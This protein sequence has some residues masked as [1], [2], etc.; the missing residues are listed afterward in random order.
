MTHPER[1]RRFFA[2]SVLV[3]VVLTFCVAPALHEFSHIGF[4]SEGAHLDAT[5]V[6]CSSTS[7]TPLAND[8]T[9]V[10]CPDPSWSPVAVAFESTPR[11]APNHS[12]H[13]TRAPPQHTS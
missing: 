6:V 9:L 13:D 7:H 2:A 5:C 12:S 10:D 4:G 8:A 11:L 3:V 1:M